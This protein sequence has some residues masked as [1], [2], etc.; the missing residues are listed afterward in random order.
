MTAYEI[1][2]R[3]VIRDKIQSESVQDKIQAKTDKI[4]AETEEKKI[5][6][7]KILGFCLGLNFASD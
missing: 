5:C 1:Q 7:K 6:Q 3:Y 4:Q 2:L